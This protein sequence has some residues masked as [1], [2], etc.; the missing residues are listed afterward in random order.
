[1]IDIFVGA[2]AGGLGTGALAVTAA[3]RMSSE[4]LLRLIAG[5]VALFHPRGRRRRDARRLLR[6]LR[7]RG[8]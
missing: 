1:M 2:T 7:A 4:G 6:E 3:R 8:R 5:L